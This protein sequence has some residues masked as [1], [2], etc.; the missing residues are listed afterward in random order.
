[1][2]DETSLSITVPTVLYS[3]NTRTVPKLMN[4]ILVRKPL[5]WSH[6]H[7][8]EENRCC[9]FPEK[10]LESAFLFKILPVLFKMP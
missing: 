8:V 7:I 9:R 2:V 6:L 3:A 5:K 4:S 10:S 1:M